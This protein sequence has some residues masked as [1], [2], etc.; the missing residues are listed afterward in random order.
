MV[1]TFS[2]ESLYEYQDEDWI[3]DSIP[4]VLAWL[5]TT[6]RNDAR[7]DYTLDV[8]LP[9]DSTSQRHETRITWNID[10]LEARDK[11]LNSHVS[12]LLSGHSID[13]EHIAENAAYG[14]SLVAICLLLPGRRVTGME[15]GRSPDFLLDGTT[16]EARRG[17]EVAGRLTGGFAAL[18][19]VHQSKR[20]AL[21][22][23]TDLVEVHLSLW[24]AMPAVAE[25][26]QVKP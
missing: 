17:V 8:T 1:R 26:H 15:K 19:H 12:R 24:C 23:R 4:F 18:K 9:S 5:G 25:F 14:L 16:P 21:V 3:V 7:V 13:R 6:G 10:A 20:P 2:L 11:G 22:D